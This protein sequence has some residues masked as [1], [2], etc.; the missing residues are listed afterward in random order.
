[1]CVLVC[2]LVGMGLIDR[3]FNSWLRTSYIILQVATPSTSL[4]I[5][6]AGTFIAAW[7]EARVVHQGTLWV[8][9]RLD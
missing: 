4:T 8:V 5:Y 7:L 2:V 6:G 1:M 3:L 9:K